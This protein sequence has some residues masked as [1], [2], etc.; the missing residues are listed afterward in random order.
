MYR[1]CRG[2][3]PKRCRQ[4]R[5]FYELL[6]HTLPRLR[7]KV[8]ASLLYSFTYEMVCVERGLSSSL[9]SLSMGGSA[10]RLARWYYARPEQTQ[11]SCVR[12]QEKAGPIQAQQ[13]VRR[14]IGSAEPKRG[15]LRPVFFQITGRWA[16][17]LILGCILLAVPV[18]SDLWAIL[19]SGISGQQYFVHFIVY[20]PVFSLLCRCRCLQMTIHQNS[21]N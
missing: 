8:G 11:V 4:E 16:L 6:P 7:I 2:T 20:S 17:V 14:P 5:L 21:W 12:P 3:K 9:Y 18:S 19:E 10:V 15:S 13:G 1:I